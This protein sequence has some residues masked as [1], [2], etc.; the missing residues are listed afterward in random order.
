M[1]RVATILLVITPCAF[2]AST[3]LAL[4]ATVGAAGRRGL[5]IKG[6]SSIEACSRAKVVLLDKTG[7]LTT[8]T[9]QLATIDAFDRTEDQ[10]LTLA[11]I[12]EKHS[13]HPLARAVAAAEHRGL[14][15]DDPEHFEV[16]S[17]HGILATYAGHRVA[18]GNQRFLHR[19]NVTL[20]EAIQVHAARREETGYTLAY[21]LYD[22]AVIGVLGF[23]AQPRP[24]A[25]GVIAG[26]RKLGVRHIVMVT[27]DR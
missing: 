25:A 1:E 13:T 7:T 16:T 10:V 20:P 22:D 12:A 14:N 27:G 17:G 5:V 26:L 24:S 9:P 19:H 6:G 11:A 15:I 4:I 8:S 23:L 2:S 18:I 3:P 21:V